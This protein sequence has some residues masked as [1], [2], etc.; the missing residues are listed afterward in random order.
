MKI[1]SE[2][3]SAIVMLINKGMSYRRIGKVFGV[4][5]SVVQEINRKYN[6]KDLKRM[7]VLCGSIDDLI[8][9]EHITICKHCEKSIQS[10]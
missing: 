5:H 7:C 6:K 3:N 10:Y 1:K 4:S 8:D 9:S 2:R